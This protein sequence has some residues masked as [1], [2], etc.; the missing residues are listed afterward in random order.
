[1]QRAFREAKRWQHDFVGTEH[2]L[3]GLLCDSDGPAVHLLRSLQVAPDL[4]LEKVELSLKR[5]DGGQAME[6]FPLSPASKR[7]FRCASDEAAALRHQMIGPEHLLLGLLRERDC[8]AAQLLFAHGIGLASVRDA[9]ARLPTDAFREVQVQAAEAPRFVPGDNPSADELERWI[10]PTLHATEIMADPQRPILNPFAAPTTPLEAARARLYRTQL[11]YAA[12][13]GYAFG[14]WMAGWMLASVLAL[15]GVAVAFTRSSWAGIIA[16]AGCGLLITP[17]FHRP[18]DALTP[19][20]L[21]MLGAF[22]GSFIGD[23]WGFATQDPTPQNEPA[24]DD[25]PDKP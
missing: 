17:L 14:H 1:M 22:L 11:V 24:D 16:G 6:Q 10:A 12:L 7:V 5:H 21:G 23:G 3:Y 25:V 8:E 13:L 18:P 19:L 15:L 20:M 9:I 4:M 2:L